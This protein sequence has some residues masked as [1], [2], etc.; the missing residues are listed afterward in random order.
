MTPG[1]PN[2]VSICRSTPLTWRTLCRSRLCLWIP[3]TRNQS[4]PPQ[5]FVLSPSS[6]VRNPPSERDS[7]DDR[8]KS[9]QLKTT[10]SLRKEVWRLR[11]LLFIYKDGTLYVVFTLYRPNPNRDQLQTRD[12]ESKTQKVRLSVPM[13]PYS[14][15]CRTEN[16]EDEF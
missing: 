4:E 6:S 9:G 5:I 1:T 11:M 16:F 2:T 10:S 13:F 3:L 15:L 8:G 7:M 12:T 14:P